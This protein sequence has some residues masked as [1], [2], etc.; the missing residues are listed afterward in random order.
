MTQTLVDFLYRATNGASNRAM[1]ERID[2]THTT[3]QAH[4]AGD[5]TPGDTVA[6]LCRAYNV[7][8]VEAA[9]VA[10]WTTAEEVRAFS[11]GLQLADIADLELTKELLRRVASGSAGTAITEPSPEELINNV[12]RE[13]EDARKNGRQSDYAVAADDGPNETPGDDDEDDRA[14]L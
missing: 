9:I 2:M 12:I 10:G 6:R 3:L 7:S 5:K 1:A 4:I 13:V 11:G 8:F 14:G